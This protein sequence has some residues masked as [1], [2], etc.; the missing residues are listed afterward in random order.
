MVKQNSIGY[1]WNKDIFA[2]RRT[3]LARK[4]DVQLVITPYILAYQ[5]PNAQI[6]EYMSKYMCKGV[7]HSSS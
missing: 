3:L 5:L 4:L 6:A 2:L 7:H 1:V